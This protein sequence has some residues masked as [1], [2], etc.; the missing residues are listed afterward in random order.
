MTKKS[1][2]ERS[3]LYPFGEIRQP[4]ALKDLWREKGEQ[5]AQSSRQAE[6]SKSASRQPDLR[7]VSRSSDNSESEE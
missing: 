5:I 2:G 4:E 6:Q 1:V 7:I 3:P